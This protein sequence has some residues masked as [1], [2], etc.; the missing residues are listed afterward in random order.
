LAH[1]AEAVKQGEVQDEPPWYK[2]KAQEKVMSNWWSRLVKKATRLLSPLAIVPLTA[3][4][5]AQPAP[6]AAPAA[7]ARPALWKIADEDTTIYLFG[8]IHLLP[9]G[10]EWRTP[11]LEKA[12]A[13]SDALVLE[14][15]LGTDLSRTGRKMME[16]G[17]SPG[18][19]P[20]LE[21]VPED[22]R[23]AL[24]KLIEKAG[25]STRSL[26]RMETWAAAMSL[27]ASSFRG[28]GFKAEAGAEQGLSASF[29]DT[30]KPIT[31]LET[32]E[33][34]FGFFDSLSEESQRAFL[35][36]SID[37][38]E[39]A[40]RQLEAMIQAWAAG[41]TDAIAR[42]F[43]SE[44]ALSPEL[45]QILMVGRNKAWAE[46]LDKRL[47]EPGTLMVAVGAGHL[48][49]QDSVQT[50]LKALGIRTTRLQ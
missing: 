47:D 13:A 42:T 33:Q 9:P 22:K 37:D 3:C 16:M 2:H 35:V 25:I 30:G 5:T 29:R 44:T 20:L 8:T 4:A 43:D 27:F 38:P 12:I 50:M 17:L 15:Q 45:R 1:G 14:T 36:G 24:Q 21:R 18:L 11:A 41:D 39:E 6:Q 32:V 40:R 19:P 28:M 7:Q 10:L 23:P 48:A 31:G 34:Q 46:W 49:G 26:D